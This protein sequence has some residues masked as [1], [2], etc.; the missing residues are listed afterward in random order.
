MK[1]PCAGRAPMARQLGY[2]AAHLALTLWCVRGGAGLR[3]LLLLTSVGF[4]GDVARLLASRPHAPQLT[5]RQA[6][7]RPPACVPA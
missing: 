1:P 4:A 3:T 2:L 7:A 6:H 5:R